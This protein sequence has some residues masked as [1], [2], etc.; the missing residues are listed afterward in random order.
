MVSRRT[1]ASPCDLTWLRVD[2]SVQPAHPRS[3]A[4]CCP[5]SR[6]PWVESMGSQ[7]DCIDRKRNGEGLR[8][9]TWNLFQEVNKLPEK[10]QVNVSEMKKISI[11]PILL[12][13]TVLTGC[14]SS[15]NCENEVT[16]AFS[17]YA[18]LVQQRYL[19]VE[20]PEE[21]RAIIQ[22]LMDSSFVVK[23]STKISG[24]TG[25][26]VINR[27]RLALI[28]TAQDDLKTADQHVGR[29]LFDLSKLEDLPPNWKGINKKSDLMKLLETIDGTPA[30]IKKENR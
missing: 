14:S 8:T 30:F 29:A 26:D 6:W 13:C 27:A 4:L 20:T 22:T 25:F 15:R 1:G 2:G 9:Q 3:P 16:E 21:A 5:R 28:A 24:P 10:V 23:E 12:C 19:H 18:L 7:P 11:L 17:T